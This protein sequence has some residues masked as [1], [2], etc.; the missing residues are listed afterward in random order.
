MAMF[1]VRRAA[2]RMPAYQ[3]FLVPGDL[4]ALWAYVRWLRT[5]R[6]TMAGGD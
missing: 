2:L 5:E 4:E 1:F 6:K 3:R